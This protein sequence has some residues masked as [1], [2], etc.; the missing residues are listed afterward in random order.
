MKNIRERMNI[1]Y[2]GYCV[3]QTVK[4]MKLSILFT[5]FL[6]LNLSASVLSQEYV[7]LS[8]KPERNKPEQKQEQKKII[9]GRVTDENGDPLPGVSIILKGT[10][11]ESFTDT[12]GLFAIQAPSQS[13]VLVFSFFGMNS[14]EV[15]VDK[16]KQISVTLSSFLRELKEVV[17]TGYQTLPKERVT[18]SFVKLDKE[19]LNQ[20]EAATLGEKLRGHAAGVL[21]STKLVDGEERAVFSIRGVNTFDANTQPLFVVDGFPI[22]GT[23]AHMNP[24]DIESVNILQDAASASIWGTRAANGVVVITTKKGNKSD[25]PTIS[26]SASAVIQPKPDLGSLRVADSETTINVLKEIYKMN[27][28]IV[29]AN[30][31][32]N[33]ALEII[34]KYSADTHKRDKLLSELAKN[35]VRKE[36]EDLFLQTG[37]EERYNL[38]IRGGSEKYRYYNSLAYLTNDS[39]YIGDKNERINLTLNNELN[40]TNKLKLTANVSLNHIKRKLNSPGI[41]P[42]QYSEGTD[43]LSI[44]SKILD[45][46]GNPIRRSAINATPMNKINDRLSSFGLADLGFNLY[47]DLNYRN[48]ERKTKSLRAQLG[49]DYNILDGLN[50]SGKFILEDYRSEKDK[51]YAPESYQMRE[52]AY[53]SS[54]IEND[55]FYGEKLVRHIP[56]GHYLGENNTNRRAY[57]VRNQL[58]FYKEIKDFHISLLG[59]VEA[60]ETLEET[61]NLDR[62]GYDPQL[63]TFEHVDQATLSKGIIGNNGRFSMNIENRKFENKNRYFSY[64]FNGGL[65]YKHKYNL[66]LSYRVDDSNLFGAK[67][68]KV[69]L[70]SVG[71]S[72]MISN[73]DFFDLNFVD[74]LKLRL[75]YGKN[76]NIARNSSAYPILAISYWKNNDIGAKFMDI[77]DHGNKYLT[78]EVTKMSNIGVDFSLF[79]NSLSGTVEYYKKNSVDVLGFFNINSMYGY[80]GQI[81]NN[82]EIDNEGCTIELSGKVGGSFKYCPSINISFN[83]NEVKHVEQEDDN[84]FNVFSDGKTRPRVGASISSVYGLRFAGLDKEGRP[85]VYDSKDKIIGFDDPF[86]EDLE[87][88]IRLGQTTPKFHG[89]FTNRFCYK[90]FTLTSLMTFRLCHVFQTRTYSTFGATRGVFYENIE[91]RWQKAGD[92][93]MTNVP[94]LYGPMEATTDQAIRYY[95]FTDQ[96]W[97]DASHIRLDNISL[98][99]VFNKDSKYLFNVFK[100]LEIGAQVSNIGLVWSA[101]KKHIDPEL[102]TLMDKSKPIYTFTFK[103]QF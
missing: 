102:N 17:V 7:N 92:E 49:L 89:G 88:V 59:G 95:E 11:L 3:K 52:L 37:V 81:I 18:G 14:K 32:T 101:N 76:G 38:S 41:K 9:R 69:P 4:I 20:V 35:D 74:Y 93:K 56:Q 10:S 54:N 24:D 79:N 68:T 78:W 30:K 25:G 19:E 100:S 91:D 28:A 15:I 57:T 21:I 86:L 83:K 48:I 2:G 34:S 55:P 26:F 33:E 94:R 50:W 44:F 103:A 84:N 8:V 5:M 61:D 73:E 23:I 13:G 40:I 98:K 96:L 77:K 63:L 64:Y 36:Y 51:Q 70:F 39:K 22:E 60:R 97:N 67:K 12:E 47:D 31:G 66:T 53:L 27:P 80:K 99:Y 71:T 6:C 58:N 42:F 75:T 43:V 65:N 46:E 82:A 29:N 16:Q 87:S 1:L 62:Y 45:E 85:T 90:N 72:W